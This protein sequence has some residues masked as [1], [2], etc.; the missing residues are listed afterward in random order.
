VLTGNDENAGTDARVFLQLFGDK[1]ETDPL[2]L[3]TTET[4]SHKFERGKSNEYDLE[5]VNVGQ[6]DAFNADILIQFYLLM[7][8]HR[9]ITSMCLMTRSEING[10]FTRLDV[11]IQLLVLFT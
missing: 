11:A 3:D 7:Y 1:G 5:S 2:L 9:L 6:V 4:N 10:E 8:N